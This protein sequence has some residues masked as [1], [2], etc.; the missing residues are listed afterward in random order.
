MSRRRVVIT[1]LGVITSLGETADELWENVCAGKSGISSIRRWDTAKYPVKIGGECLNFDVTKY[2][3]DVKEARRMDRFGQFGVAASVQAVKDAGIDFEKEDRYRCGVVIGSGIGGI[4]TIEEQN[5]ILLERG[6]SRVSPFTVPRLM[7]NAASGN[8]SI[9]FHLNGPNTTVAT[10]CATGSNAVGDGPCYQGRVPP[11]G[12]IDHDDVHH[13]SSLRRVTDDL[14]PVSIRRRS[15]TTGRVPAD[16]IVSAERPWSSRPGLG[17]R[18]SRRSVTF[19]SRWT[20]R[21]RP[22][23]PLAGGRLATLRDPSRLRHRYGGPP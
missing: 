1:G 2:G 12:F 16:T 7:A 11:M 19:G 22:G 18:W 5:K 4:E 10:A 14:L 8:V 9:A 17:G 6:V 23:S 13:I 20:R 3:V 15:T 21:L